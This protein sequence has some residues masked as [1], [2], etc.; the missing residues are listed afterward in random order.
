MIFLVGVVIGAI[1][2]VPSFGV[3]A[4]V[5]LVVLV[6]VVGIAWMVRMRDQ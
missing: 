2:E 5:V 1:E 4:G 6:V 3:L